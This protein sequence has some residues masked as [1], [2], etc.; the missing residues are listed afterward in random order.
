MTTWEEEIANA[1]KKSEG[2]YCARI[3]LRA[4]CDEDTLRMAVGCVND[5]EVAGIEP[6]RIYVAEAEYG[7]SGASVSLMLYHEQP[8]EGMTP[9]PVYPPF[10]LSKLFE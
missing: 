1:A 9:F 4:A 8:P 2:R 7:C 5:R 10:D 6:G 3:V